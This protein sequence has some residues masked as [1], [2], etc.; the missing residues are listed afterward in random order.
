MK[1]KQRLREAGVKIVEVKVDELMKGHGGISC[2]TGRLK[3]DKL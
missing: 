1:T 2:M 3:R